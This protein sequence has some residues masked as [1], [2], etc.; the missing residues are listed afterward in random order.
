MRTPRNSSDRD[1][2]RFEFC[3]SQGC[4]TH[5]GVYIRSDR[6]KSLTCLLDAMTSANEY[7]DNLDYGDGLPDSPAQAFEQDA[8]REESSDDEPKR[9]ALPPP[10]VPI[11]KQPPVATTTSRPLSRE[12]ER[13][14]RRGTTEPTGR[15]GMTCFSSEPRPSYLSNV[16]CMI[17]RRS[18]PS[19]VRRPRDGPRP[20]CT[21]P[22]VVHPCR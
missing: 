14:E 13:E 4:V 21:M 17:G 11:M 12:R 10:A 7:D 22:A 15:E 19:C 6:I 2:W 5:G 16:T 8:A 20:T 3:L 18:A 1:V 9:A